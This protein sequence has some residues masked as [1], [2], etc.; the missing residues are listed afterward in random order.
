VTRKVD[1]LSSDGLRGRAWAFTKAQVDRAAEIGHTV[2]IE[3][4]KPNTDHPET[5]AHSRFKG[6]TA[7]R[8]VCTCGYT[9]VWQVGAYNVVSKVGVHV[10]AA[11]PVPQPAEPEIPSVSLQPSVGA[12]G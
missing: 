4:K 9:S 5:V 3:E 7:Y 10:G 11:E 8:V 6:H 12:S 2:T 1:P